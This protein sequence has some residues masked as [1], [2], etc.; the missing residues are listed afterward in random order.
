[1]K[2][3]AAR[4]G[5]SLIE[6]MVVT[7]IL[8]IIFVILYS[9]IAFSTSVAA[10]G[11]VSSDLEARVRTCL[12][13]CKREFQ[14]AKISGT[15]SGTWEGNNLLGV[16]AGTSD[17]EFRYQIPVNRLGDG[18]LQFGY[19]DSMED[20]TGAIGWACV[21]RFVPEKMLQESASA[22]TVTSPA[23]DWTSVTEPTLETTVLG[24]DVNGDGDKADTYLLG[25]IVRYVIDM[26][27]P[28]IS[29]ESGLA[30][31]VLLRWDTTDSTYYASLTD[32]TPLFA[33]HPD[34]GSSKGTAVG[35]M[36][37]MYDY[38]QKAYMAREGTEVMKFR[39][40][41]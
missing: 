30:D 16:I 37:G 36:M 32:A 24:L 15:S 35:V 34:G 5:F 13:Y 26:D 28:A 2:R 11:T 18:T 7:A 41:Q 12:D 3:N 21:L 39:N 6:L 29:T 14:M 25:K 27:T 19:T 22:P 20:D 4:K 31:R 1:M 23:T 38:L 10:S 40:V 9:I 8:A 17:T 33:Y